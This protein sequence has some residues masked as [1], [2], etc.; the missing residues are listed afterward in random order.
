MGSIPEGGF[1]NKIMKS[2]VLG[3]VEVELEVEEIKRISKQFLI[4]SF[5]IPPYSKSF[6]EVWYSDGVWYGDNYHPRGGY[7]GKEKIRDM[8]ELEKAVELILN[9]LKT[10]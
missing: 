5:L 4:D 3:K 8:T 6:D 9:E 1:T 10:K 2:I 7:F